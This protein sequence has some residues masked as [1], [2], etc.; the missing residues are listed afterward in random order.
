MKVRNSLITVSCMP[1]TLMRIILKYKS[2]CS[3]GA[4]LAI[5]KYLT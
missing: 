3:K 4:M 5:G 2:Q 1:I